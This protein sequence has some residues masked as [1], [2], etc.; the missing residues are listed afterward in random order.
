MRFQRP[1][2]KRRNISR[3]RVFMSMTAAGLWILRLAAYLGVGDKHRRFQS[4]GGEKGGA[5][6]PFSLSPSPPA[7]RRR[8]G[9][10]DALQRDNR[11]NQACQAHK[12]H[13]AR[14]DQLCVVR[15]ALLGDDHSINHRGRPSGNGRCKQPKKASH[16]YHSEYDRQQSPERY[17]QAFQLRFPI[18][19]SPSRIT[20]VIWWLNTTPVGIRCQQ[21]EPHCLRPSR[22]SRP[23]YH[24]SCPT[25]SG[26][27]TP[28][29]L[30]PRAR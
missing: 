22:P 15:A 29:T 18:S 8:S 16:Y 20:S 28:W 3:A 12:H 11:Q 7:R 21:S 27:W 25:P 26:R 1:C 9:N 10:S 14:H 30:S 6:P 24:V 13:E 2:R 19:S 4:A 17:L 5:S 23:C